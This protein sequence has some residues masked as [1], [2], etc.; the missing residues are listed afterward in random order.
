MP[1]KNKY[2]SIF[3]LIAVNLYPIFGVIY[4][5]WDIFEIVILYVA[6]TFIVGLSNAL[7]MSFV[8]SDQK[9]VMIPFFLFHYNFFVAIQTVFIILL[10]GTDN[11]FEFMSADGWFN[12]LATISRKDVLISIGLLGI[13]HIYSFYNDFY[14]KRIF[15][16]YY[17]NY[18]FALPY[19]RIFVQQFVVLIGGAVSLLFDTPMGYLIILIFFKTIIDLWVQKNLSLIKESALRSNGPEQRYFE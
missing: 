5:G 6:E 15:E 14:R 18:F 17:L 9:Q 13:G 2:L 10:F 12:F 1:D 19:R 3:V 16:I 7:Q 8:K 4:F 11:G